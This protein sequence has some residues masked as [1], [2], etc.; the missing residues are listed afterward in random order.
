MRKACVDI[1]PKLSEISGQSVRENELTKRM[2][3]FLKDRSRW[4]KIQSYKKLGQFIITL[5]NFKISDSLVHAFASMV[6]SK[7]ASL[8]TEKEVFYSSTKMMCLD[9][10]C[11][12]ILLPSCFAVVWAE[13]MA[14][15]E[16]GV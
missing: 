10:D 16:E 2:I 4:V 9:S 3:E 7:I 14:A 8:A 13:E 1:L 15:P 6:S 11:L 12:C 5:Q